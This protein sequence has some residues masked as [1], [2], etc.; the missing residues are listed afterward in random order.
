MVRSDSRRRRLSRCRLFVVVYV[1]I[2]ENKCCGW[3]IYENV[4]YM[5]KMNEFNVNDC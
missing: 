1:W 5:C 2:C 4:I 3:E